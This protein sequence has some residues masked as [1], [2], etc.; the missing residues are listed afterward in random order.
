MTVALIDGD[1]V[2]YRCAAANEQNDVGLACWQAGEMIERI[3]DETQASSYS[4][5]LTGSDNFRFSIY[6]EYKANRKDAIKPKWH[7]AIRE[8][9]CERWNAQV[10]DGC[11]ADD[12]MGI[13]QEK[14]LTQVSI[15]CSIDKDMM[16][17]PGHH[18]NFVKKEFI[19][20]EE[21]DATRWL[22]YQAIMGDKVDN[23]PGFDGKMRSKVPKFMQWMIDE[24]E[25]F[26]NEAE[27]YAFVK[28]QH[29]SPEMLDIYLKC[30]WIWREE[31]N[32]WKNPMERSPT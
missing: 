5:F 8:Y 3:L 1:I 20:V 23:I 27:M 21:P 16:M 24:L 14:S 9:L 6:S 15:I 31:G 11:E 32:I 22:Y 4:C 29:Q 12:M 10:S 18:Y 19:D 7:S 28:D 2:N 25:E 17:I 13:A 26:D 30:L